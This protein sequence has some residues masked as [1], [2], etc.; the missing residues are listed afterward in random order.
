VGLSSRTW[1][2]S[3]LRIHKVA[4]SGSSDE[5]RR[6][7]AT[8]QGV[9]TVADLDPRHYK[10]GGS[11]TGLSA[12][13]TAGGDPSGLSGTEWRQ[14]GGGTIVKATADW[15]AEARVPRDV[16][17]ALL[18]SRD[19]RRY[20]GALAMLGQHHYLTTSHLETLFWPSARA[21]QRGIA[22]LEGWGLVTRWHQQ[23]PRFGGWRKHADIFLLTACGAA[24]L[25][26]SSR[27]DP[28]PLIRRAW[29]A[30]HYAFHIH[31]AL[32]T[33]AFFLSLIRASAGLGEG[34]YHWVSDDSMRRAYQSSDLDADVAPDGWGRY[35]T[36]DREV[37]F[38]LEYD[39]GTES[40]QRIRQKAAAA[41]KAK[42]GNVLWIAPGQAR[43]QTIRTSL[44]RVDDAR[45]TGFWSTHTG[46]LREAGPLGEAWL[47]LG[48]SSG[49][50]RLAEL[51]GPA[52][53]DRQAEDC[54]GKPGWWERRPGGGEGA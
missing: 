28:K 29:S 33:N 18:R 6:L 9:Q 20:I 39:K 54:L 35:L 31:H 24:V 13:R 45:L 7:E 8:Q 49:R 47:P 30:W 16:T 40:P 52:R 44:A 2:F 38:H 43:E 3:G 36:P 19:R 11:P 48:A 51:P 17:A 15:E 5:K 4:S 34:L 22:T 50:R 21:A 14:A 10:E 12:E 41:A 1:S 42:A 46:L 37:P 53:T 27:E 25:A 26:L 23:E 32:E